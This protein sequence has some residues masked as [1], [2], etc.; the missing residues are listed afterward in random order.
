M[1]PHKQIESQLQASLRVV[2]P[3]ADSSSVLLRPCPDPK[4][5]DYQTSALMALAK[6]RNLNPRAFAENVVKNLD[7]TG[8][9]EKV[10]IAGAGFLN[11]RLKTSALKKTLESA[12][13]GGALFFENATRPK[14]VV[15]DF[16]S[17]NVAKPMHVGHI[18]STFLGD[19][20]ARALRLLGHRVIADNHIG[21]WGTQFGKLLL[22]WKKGLNLEHLKADP[23]SEM[24]RLYKWI[25]GAAES[26]PALLEEARV[27]L[28]KLQSGDPENLK[29]W[30]EMIT[31]SE[32]QFD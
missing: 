28:V 32:K 5:G 20:L 22:G 29:I 12:A 15:V 13:S 23:I 11:F 25:N 27:E 6:G 19:S 18:R 3:D 4:F 9:C 31:L 1:L 7:V 30:R 2:L 24:G 17:P 21:D 14:T 26:D 10:E 16:S 8:T